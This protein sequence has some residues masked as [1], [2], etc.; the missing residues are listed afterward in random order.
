MSQRQQLGMKGVTMDPYC[1]YNGNSN[2]TRNRI[3]DHHD[4]RSGSHRRPGPDI[5]TSS[6]DSSDD[7]SVADDGD[8][9]DDSNYRYLRNTLDECDVD[10]ITKSSNY[11]TDLD[12][13]A[14][15]VGGTVTNRVSNG[16]HFDA[17]QYK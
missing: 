14:D 10:T 11:P 5:D 16:Q 3:Q 9:D 1:N 17:R 4:N 8:G 7:D 13:V 6:G 2:G 15:D 12:S